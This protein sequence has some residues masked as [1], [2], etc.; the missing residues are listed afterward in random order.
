MKAGGCRTAQVLLISLL[1][2]AGTATAAPMTTLVVTAATSPSVLHATMF[3][4]VAKG[5][6]EKNGLKVQ[7]IPHVNAVVALKKVIDGTAQVG[8]A[9]PT[10]LAQTIAQG[11]HVKGIFASNGDATGKVPTDGYFA[12]VAR[13]ASGIREGHLEDLRGK[14]IGVRRASDFHEYLFSALAAKG[15]DP[16]S[17]VTIVDTSDLLGALQNGS[18]DAI[19]T[20]EPA[21]AQ[22]YRSTSDTVLVERGGNHIQFVDL[23]VVSTQY[24]AT[25]P[26]TIKRFITAFA[27]AAQYVRAHPDETTDIMV[28]QP[29]KGFSR[30]M[31]RPAIGFLDPDVRVSKATAQ[32]AQEGSDFAIKIGALQRVPAF[33]EMVDLRIL[34]QVE[35]ERPELFNDLS[36]VPDTLKL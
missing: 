21:A 9:A 11:A 4:G 12:V 6:F 3:V 2:A 26:G 35:R 32:A 17:T 36:P 25:H 23:R 7:L 30:E 18:V 8:A 13:K 24:L 5:I 10:A 29:L 33:E 22:I 31:V 34:R 19:V 14:K 27:E 16:V 1:L 20:A 28:Q 15:F